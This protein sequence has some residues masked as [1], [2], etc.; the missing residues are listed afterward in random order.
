MNVTYSGEVRVAYINFRYPEDAREA[1][2][3]KGKLVLFERPVRVESVYHKKYQQNGPVA[4]GGGGGYY[5]PRDHYQ[6]Q[7]PPRG[8]SPP[9]YQQQRRPS[10]HQGPDQ[11]M[12]PKRDYNPNYQKG[13]GQHGQQNDYRRG[14]NEKFPYHLD[15]IP[16]KKMRKQPGRCLLEI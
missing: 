11:G 8:M 7:G 14:P 5:Q 2:H 13:G 16:Q 4:G 12:P 3:A 1:K 10:Y 15:H 9:P 6:P